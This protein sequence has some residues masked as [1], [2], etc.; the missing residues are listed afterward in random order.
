MA[1]NGIIGI[2][3]GMTQVFQDDGTLVGCTV[4]A[5]GSMRGGAASDEDEGR[6]RSRA[7]GPRG[8]RQAAARQQSHDRALQKGRCGADEGAAGNP[9]RRVGGRNQSRRS[10]A[11]GEFQGRRACRCQRRQQGQR[12]C[13]RREALALRRRR[14]DA[15][16][17]VSPRAGRHRRQFV[18]VA[19][20]E[21]PA[22]S[23]S[24]GQRAGHR[25]EPESR[26]SGH[27][28]EPAAG[29]DRCRAQAERTFSSRRFARPS[30]PSRAE[31]SSSLQG[32]SGTAG[33]SL[34]Q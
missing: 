18:P 22:F 33:T 30:R 26:E 17:D 29:R 23:G 4:S 32:R 28:R 5:G 19:R 24:H 3:L 25:A 12:L 1:V 11:G 10:R 7:T 34:H 8:I 20:V 14:R 31:T 13:R 15:R 21:E 16:F 9:H 6:L 2:K 27:R